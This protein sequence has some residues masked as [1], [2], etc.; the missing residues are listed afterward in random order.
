MNEIEINGSTVAVKEWKGQRVVTFRDI[1]TVHERPDGTAKRNFRANKEHFIE[2]EDY[3][4]AEVISRL[5]EYDDKE[6]VADI[7]NLAAKDVL[8]REREV[9]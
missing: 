2:N 5:T 3:F 9:R 4:I 7:V 1:D 6:E 8:R